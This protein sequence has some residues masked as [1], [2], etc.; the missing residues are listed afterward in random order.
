MHLYI[1]F[2]IKYLNILIT[3]RPK[4]VKIPIYILFSY[5]AIT[6]PDIINEGNKLK[7]FK[8]KIKI[9]NLFLALIMVSLD[10]L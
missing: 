3:I 8:V 7:T 6:I 2:I 5:V 10:K 9:D 4:I 1:A